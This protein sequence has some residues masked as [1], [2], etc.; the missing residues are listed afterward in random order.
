MA[1]IEEEIRKPT[2]EP[3]AEPHGF[4]AESLQTDLPGN[5]GITKPS[6]SRDTAAVPPPSSALP[7][8]AAEP[9]PPEEDAL[10]ARTPA[11]ENMP[12]KDM[13]AAGG[14]DFT[15][16]QNQA[17]AAKPAKPRSLFPAL[18]AT[19]LAGA[20]LGVGGSYGL[21]FLEA[22]HTPL[23]G[24]DDRVKELDARLDAIEGKEAAASQ[25][26]RSALSALESRVAG[27]EEAARK[28][29]ELATA[30]EAAAQKATAAR[31]E[32]QESPGRSGASSEVRDLGPLEARLAA[33]EQKVAQAGPGAAPKTSVRAEPEMDSAAAKESARA[34]QIAIVAGDVLRKIDHGEDFSADLTALES[35][36]VSQPALASLREASASAVASERELAAQFSE[37]SGKMIEAEQ[38]ASA[39]QEEN[40]L[41]RLTRNAKSWVNVRRVGDRSGA[42]VQSVAARIESALADHDIAAAYNFFE[43]LPDVAK[44]VGLRW[45][46]A[47]KLRLDALNAAKSIEAE[48]VATLGKPKP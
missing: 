47:L 45:G 2:E 16:P 6:E 17:L 31:S 42:D 18:A 40:L 33:L 19:A 36:G 23:P 35:L 32:I 8:T 20:L 15:A 5:A 43:E 28:A 26:A 12:D 21:R 4:E 27:A 38:A 9:Q 3:G 24:S 1:G 34:Q 39:G 25:G 41:D 13:P 11:H 29:A 14:Q 7:D 10:P 44:K 48:A 37:L 30:A 46:E 22:G